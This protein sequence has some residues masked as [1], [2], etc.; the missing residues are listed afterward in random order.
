MTVRAEH[1][2]AG[3]GQRAAM[4][5]ETGVNA[6][7]VADGSAGDIGGRAQPKYVRAAGRALGRRL[8][9]RG[10]QRREDR[11]GGDRGPDGDGRGK[12][13]KSVPH[14]SAHGRLRRVAEVTVEIRKFDF[15]KDVLC[16]T[17]R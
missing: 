5:F 12:T 14:V 9:V 4:L 15:W 10:A 16:A 1:A 17:R 13:E 8:R 7:L 3:R 6:A 2:I 11:Y